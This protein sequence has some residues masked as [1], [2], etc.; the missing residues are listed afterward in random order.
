MF[1]ELEES[2][3]NYLGID[4]KYLTDSAVTEL[5]EIDDIGRKV[6][7]LRRMILRTQGSLKSVDKVN[8]MSN[9]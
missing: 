4:V 3:L 9:R 6:L 7:H 2:I 8:R 5:A 1:D